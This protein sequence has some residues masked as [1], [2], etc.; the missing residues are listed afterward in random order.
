MR[1]RRV[2]IIALACTARCSTAT[3]APGTYT[4]TGRCGGGNLGVM[5]KL[6]VTG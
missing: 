6:K 1:D 4:I 3:W 2:T 5:R